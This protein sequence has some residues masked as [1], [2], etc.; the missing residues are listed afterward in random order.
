MVILHLFNTWYK[1]KIHLDAT[2]APIDKNAQKEHE[3]SF[4]KDEI[5]LFDNQVNV[6]PSWHSHIHI[7]VLTSY[8]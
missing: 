6:R 3:S 5:N 1:F 4:Y 2:I 7:K 8:G